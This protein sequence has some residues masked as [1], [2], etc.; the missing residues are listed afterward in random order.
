MTGTIEENFREFYCVEDGLSFTVRVT[1]L[2][3]GT[4]QGKIIVTEGAADFNALYYG[5][6]TDDGDSYGLKG[7]LNMNGDDKPDWDG[8]T[9]LSDPG[10]G[11]AG[12]DKPTYLTTGEYYSFPLA[13]DSFDDVAELGIRATS[14]ST[15]EGSIKCVLTPAG[16]KDDHHDGG[17][18]KDA[19]EP[20]LAARDSDEDDSDDS[21]ESDSRAAEAEAPPADEMSDEDFFT[22]LAAAVGEVEDSP[23]EDTEEEPED[24]EALF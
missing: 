11:K 6:D 4:F 13:I 10:L 21:E 14:T 23:P 22:S 15:P 17:D 24:A 8:A 7:N 12:A 5:D 18:D 20:A 19:V 2:P 1:Q 9:K 16:E 3:D